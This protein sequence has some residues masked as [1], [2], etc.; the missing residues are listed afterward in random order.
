MEPTATSTSA[1]YDVLAFGAHPDD[2]EMSIG[3]TIARFTKSG[4]KVLMVSL[5]RGEASTYGTVETREKEAAEAARILGADHLLLDFPDTRVENTYERRLVVARLIRAHRPTLVL[6]P[7]HTNPGT[8]RDGRANTDHM[9]TGALARDAIKLA[10]F[11]RVLPD[12]PPHEVH[13]ILYYIPPLGMVPA[14]VVDVSDEEE[15]LM[16]AIQAYATQMAIQRRANSI[17]EVLVAI[18][19]WNGVLIG[20]RLGEVFASDET[21]EATPEDLLRL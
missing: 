12:L 7:Y 15:T 20:K 1:P 8:H 11:R 17:L 9:A 19:R 18:R 13:R 16:R 6:A 21:L 10:R 14:L 5:T 3:G 2:L 4:R